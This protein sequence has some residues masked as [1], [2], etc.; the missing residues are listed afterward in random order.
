M[1]N[2]KLIKKFSM[3]IKR[4]KQIIIGIF[5]TPNHSKRKANLPAYI[6]KVINKP[7]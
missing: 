3:Q 2:Y 6:N 4:K 1:Q 7:C 5:A